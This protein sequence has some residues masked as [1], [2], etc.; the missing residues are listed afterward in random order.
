MGS[1]LR[2]SL[3]PSLSLWLFGSL[4]WWTEINMWNVLVGYSVLLALHIML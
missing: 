1:H 4:D 2:L 3:S